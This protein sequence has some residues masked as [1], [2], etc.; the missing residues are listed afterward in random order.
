[1]NAVV[2]CQAIELP[3]ED[4]ADDEDEYEE[5]EEEDEES[6][7][8][9]ATKQGKGKPPAVKEAR[10]SYQHD[11]LVAELEATKA[12]AEEDRLA[13]VALE[14][15]VKDLM[16]Q[17]SQSK[18]VTAAASAHALEVAEFKEVKKA[19]GRR[20]VSGGSS[21]KARYFSLKRISDTLESADESA[22]LKKD[23]ILMKMAMYDENIDSEW[24]EV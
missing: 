11:S 18:P 6:P 23:N 1:M 14:K 21:V 17:M 24:D 8:K 12:A 4:E 2:C 5:E 10:Q 22:R 20:R 15:Q 7:R 3:D 9:K 19:A 16:R 13:R